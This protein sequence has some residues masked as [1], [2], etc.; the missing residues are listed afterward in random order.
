MLGFLVLFAALILYP[1]KKY[2]YISVFLYISFLLGKG[3][4]FGLW[5]SGI[6]GVKTMDLALLYTFIINSLLLFKQI[7]AKKTIQKYHETWF[8]WYKIFL[9]FLMFSVLFSFYHY[10]FTLFQILQGGRSFL[11]VLS[12]P[13]FFS[14]TVKEIQKIL[15]ICM[16]ITVI[17]SILYSLQIVAGRPLMPYDDEYGVDGAT[18][19]MRLYNEPPLL[20]F[21]LIGSFV[22]PRFFPS[23]VNI[24]RVIFFVALMCTLGRTFIFTTISAIILA[25]LFMGKAT[26]SFKTLIVI[27]ILILPFLGIIT[28]RFEE[29]GTDNDI[30]NTISGGATNYSSGDGTMVYRMAWIYERFDYL[31]DRPLGEKIFGMGLISGSQPIVYKMYNFKLGLTNEDGEIDQL[32][33]PDTSYGNMLTKLGFVGMFLYLCFCV[34][35]FFFIYRGRNNMPFLVI[36]AADFVALFINSLSGSQLSEPRN[37]AIYFIAVTILYKS[38]QHTLLSNRR[39]R[40]LFINA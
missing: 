4:G 38:H 36:C 16:W 1:Q 35:L 2:R 9:L 28:E 3:G 14:L 17:T 15:E 26:T 18:G 6:L 7:L 22:C 25:T 40:W 24:F 11:L 13:I 29:G 10:H 32:G 31:L 34:S 30:S 20:R 33:T 12:L 37:L 39:S 21:F 8:A 19:L 27:G 23:N 5:T